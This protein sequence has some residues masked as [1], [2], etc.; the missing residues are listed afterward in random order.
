[1]RKRWLTP[2]ERSHLAEVRARWTS[3]GFSTKPSDRDATRRAIESIYDAAGLGAPHL[4]WCG[5]PLS[6]MLTANLVLWS[7]SYRAWFGWQRTHALRDRVSGSIRDSVETSLEYSVR[8]ARQRGAWRHFFGHTDP[9][10]WTSVT[11]P[12]R[13]SAQQ[14][15][16]TAVTPLV[17]D[18]VVETARRALE[19]SPVFS[20]VRDGVSRAVQAFLDHVSSL[21]GYRVWNVRQEPLVHGQHNADWVGL[22]DYFSDILALRAKGRGFSGYALLAASAGWA[23]PRARTCWVSERP[24]VVKRDDTGRLHAESGPALVYPDGWESHFWHGVHVPREWIERSRKLDLE[25]VFN[26]RQPEQRRALAEIA[27]GWD[28]LLHHR[29]IRVIDHD[30]D[31]AIGTLLG[32]DS[33][34]G[35]A[36]FLRVRCGTGRTFALPVPAECRTA[37][38]ANAWTYGLRPGDYALEVRT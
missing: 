10:P 25:Y 5:S 6:L 30:A 18:W 27:G 19:L 17:E 21:A 36:R 8:D 2:E 33:G 12:F 20:S 31:P 29:G 3:F 24:T 23:L 7:E 15:L 34:G 28:G 4:V 1:M 35:H 37:R 38:E 22:C 11:E 13:R 32:W 14:S 9:A 16:S 26:W